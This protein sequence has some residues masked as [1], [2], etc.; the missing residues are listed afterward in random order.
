[1]GQKQFRQGVHRGGKDV[2]KHWN[3]CFGL[4][5]DWTR[6]LRSCDGE[7]AEE[8]SKPSV[9]TYCTLLR[10]A[11]KGGIGRSSG[12]GGGERLDWLPTKVIAIRRSP[13]TE[14]IK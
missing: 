2:L 6:P 11:G 14:I 1:M 10:S 3:T 7:G 12:G 13:G 9:N 8:R 4:A 5:Q